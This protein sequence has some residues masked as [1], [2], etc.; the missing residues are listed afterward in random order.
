MFNDLQK[1]IVGIFSI[2]ISRGDKIFVDDYELKYTHEENA[3]QFAMIEIAC[4]FMYFFIMSISISIAIE[5]TRMHSMLEQSI[6]EYIHKRP[7]Y[8]VEL[9]LSAKGWLTVG[10]T[11]NIAKLWTKNQK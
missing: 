1:C 8:H 6:S 9:L 11:T 10:F 7:K 4:I 5:G 3:G 2:F